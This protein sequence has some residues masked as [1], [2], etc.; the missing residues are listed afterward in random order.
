MSISKS[1]DAPHSNH[2]TVMRATSRGN[3]A[4]QIAQ[5]GFRETVRMAR[6]FAVS[7]TLGN[8]V[9]LATAVVIV[10]IQYSF[11]MQAALVVPPHSVSDVVSSVSASP[12]F[13]HD[14]CPACRPTP[15]CAP[16]AFKVKRVVN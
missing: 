16:I 13:E 8:Y 3:N 4:Y 9:M 14:C 5:N 15:S 7:G 10:A 1:A 2:A 12:A 6:A 11:L